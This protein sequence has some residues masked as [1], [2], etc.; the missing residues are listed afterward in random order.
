VKGSRL[1]VLGLAYKPDVDDVRESPSLEI[2]DGLLALGAEVDY[3]DPHLPMMPPTRRSRPALA[4]I[5]LTDASVATYD[6]VVIATHHSAYDWRWLKRH[7]HLIV[8]CR[9]VMRNVAD[10]Q[11]ARVVFS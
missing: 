6:A 7:A 3:H 8:D 2:I 1:L 5:E 9:G 4:S 10:V 11:G